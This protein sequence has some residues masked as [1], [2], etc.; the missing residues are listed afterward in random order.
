MTFCRYVLTGAL[1]G[2]LQTMSGMALR[3]ETA[4][5]A[6][7]PVVD[8]RS[9]AAVSEPSLSE[10][11]AGVQMDSVPAQSEAPLPPR[12]PCAVTTHRPAGRAAQH[13]H[14]K[15]VHFGYVTPTFDN[16]H[17][18]VALNTCIMGTCSQFMLL[19]VGY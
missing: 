1:V 10:A 15:H 6:P 17:H 12:K 8:P 9:S 7:A 19:G 18:D 14:P 5:P 16:R 3:A 4:S 2:G 11:E 13:V